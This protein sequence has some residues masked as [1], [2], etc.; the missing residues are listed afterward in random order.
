MGQADQVGRVCLS[1]GGPSGGDT[2]WT[3][4]LLDQACSVREQHKPQM[5]PVAVI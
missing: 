5:C 2:E 4:E 3:P 1:C